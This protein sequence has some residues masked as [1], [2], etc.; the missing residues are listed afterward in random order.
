[1]YNMFKNMDG[2]TKWNSVGSNTYRSKATKIILPK[3]PNW[4]SLLPC[5]RV[6]RSALISD[7]GK[8]TRIPCL[9][10]L[11]WWLLWCDLIWF[12]LKPWIRKQKF[13]TAIFLLFLTILLSFFSW[14]SVWRAKQTD[15]QTGS[16]ILLYYIL[17]CNIY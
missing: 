11:S 5:L 9:H 15:W 4:G 12:C 17:F 16:N 3:L 1:M 6:R 7:H 13:Q 10:I 14:H 2:Q 8:I